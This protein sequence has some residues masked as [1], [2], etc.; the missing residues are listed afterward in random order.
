[1]LVKK[2]KLNEMGWPLRDVGHVGGVVKERMVHASK[3][4]RINGSSL[5]RP[6]SGA[7]ERGSDQ[8][9]VK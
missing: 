3:R 9:L 2:K 5:D 1:M 6:K 7:T 8:W 4:Y